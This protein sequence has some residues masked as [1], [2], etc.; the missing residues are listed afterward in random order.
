MSLMTIKLKVKQSRDRSISE[1]E[2]QLKHNGTK[3]AIMP[4]AR[5][6]G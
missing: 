3:W 1:I 4:I 2:F 6:E 5:V